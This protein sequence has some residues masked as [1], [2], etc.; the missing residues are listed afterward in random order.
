MARRFGDGGFCKTV[1]P[2]PIRHSAV[3]AKSEGMVGLTDGLDSAQCAM[4]DGVYAQHARWSGDISRSM[5][6]C[7]VLVDWEGFRYPGG[8]LASGNLRKRFS[9]SMWL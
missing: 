7:A 3:L 8:D 2:V 9:F 1:A 6:C 5:A 4:R